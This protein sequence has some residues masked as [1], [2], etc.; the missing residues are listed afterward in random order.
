MTSDL[1]HAEVLYLHSPPD[2]EGVRQKKRASTA[3]LRDAGR[4][5]VRPLDTGA[6]VDAFVACSA[7]LRDA[8]ASCVALAGVLG[9]PLLTDDAKE[10]KVALAEFPKIELVSTLE[11]I[12]D[13]ISAMGLPEPEVLRIA[14]DLRWRG[15]FAPPKREPLATWYLDLLRRGGVPFP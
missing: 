13:A 12:R 4:L 11:L 6:L 2:E 10:R 1:A 7:R 5:T 3:P 8:D 9:L 15:N 14:H